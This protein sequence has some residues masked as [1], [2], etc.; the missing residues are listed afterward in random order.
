MAA[1]SATSGLAGGTASGPDCSSKLT[2]AFSLKY[3]WPRPFRRACVR[4]AQ[5][6]PRQFFA[7][8]SSGRCR[9]TA[10]PRMRSTASRLR[11][12]HASPA[13]GRSRTPGPARAREEEA[14]GR[15]HGI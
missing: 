9:H 2:R 13:A 5:S 1:C 14:R 12:A 3:I 11:P 4:I 6:K 10:T 8:W 7:L 15:D